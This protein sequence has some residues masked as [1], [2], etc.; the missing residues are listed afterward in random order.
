M[1]KFLKGI[2]TCI[3]IGGVM[4]SNINNSPIDEASAW[5]ISSYVWSWNCWG[6][7]TTPPGSAIYPYDDE[8][9]GRNYIS[10]NNWHVN[11]IQGL[12]NRANS[13]DSTMANYITVDGIFGSKTEASVKKFQQYRNLNDDGIVGVLT[14]Q[15]LAYE[16]RSKKYK[17]DTMSGNVYVVDWS[18][19]SHNVM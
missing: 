19:N 7:D 8:Y 13:I 4:L 6:F 14:Y 3:G 16:T 17:Y 5:W 12:L 18:N 10:N 15:S 2:L 1:R 11:G 9:F